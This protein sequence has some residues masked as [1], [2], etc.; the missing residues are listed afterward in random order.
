MKTTAGR[1]SDEGF[2]EARLLAIALGLLLG[3]GFL[4]WG[5]PIALEHRV[6]LGD[7]GMSEL[8]FS[9]WPLNW[10]YIAAGVFAVLILCRW[11]GWLAID[12]RFLLAPAL[13]L[14]WQI[15]ASADTVDPTLTGYA[16]KHF[17]VLVALYLAGIALG[18]RAD[19]PPYVL[20][21]MLLAYLLA[22]LKGWGQ[23]FGGLE[24]TREFIK[25]QPNWEQ[26]PE[27]FLYRLER[28]RIFSSLVYPNAFAGLI[29]L[30]GPVSAVGLWVYGARL[31]QVWLRLG[32]TAAIAG[33]SA[34]CLWWTGSKTALAIVALLSGFLVL[35]WKGGLRWKIGLGLAAL[36]LAP[37][38]YQWKFAEY[39]REGAGSLVA[40]RDYWKAAAA[41]FV[42]NPIT[43][44]GPGT[45]YRE[46]SR[47]KD[48]ESEITRLAHQDY[49]QQAS[50]SGLPG[51]VFYLAFIGAPLVLWGLRR[52]S[53]AEPVELAVWLGVVSWA[54]QG[55]MEFCLYIPALSWTALVGLGW[56]TARAFET[57]TPAEALETST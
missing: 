50:D 38:V 55:M 42:D 14:A 20:Y 17:F 26:L 43:G 12:R 28:D 35:R 6:T 48:P 1:A 36:I 16:L 5:N 18:R 31:R 45:F 33:L 30:M 53:L 51:A 44:S 22:L 46:Y 3:L 57:E 23:H 49:L 40:R 37:L 39:F 52:A 4:K 32:L 34:A 29:L 56:L 24:A 25:S 13:W 8:M 41:T 2:R 10:G 54:L 19:V 11:R 47:R 21:G 7:G 15:I 27:A 9:T